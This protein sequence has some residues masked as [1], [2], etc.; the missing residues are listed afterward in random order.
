MIIDFLSR[1]SRRL[2]APF[3]HRALPHIV[4]SA[5]FCRGDLLD[6]VGPVPSIVIGR[7]ELLSAGAGGSSQQRGKKPLPRMR[8]GAP[9][10]PGKKQNWAAAAASRPSGIT[11][12]LM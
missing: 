10:R 3:Q 1:P 4:A 8:D 7:D 12:V 6:P 9:S 2:V 5:R 11:A